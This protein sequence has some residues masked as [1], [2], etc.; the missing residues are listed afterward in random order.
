VRDVEGRVKRLLVAALLAGCAGAP[1]LPTEFEL[2]HQKE[3]AQDDD[4]A[5]L[6]YRMVRTDCERPGATPRPKNDCA[7][8]VVREAQLHEKHHRWREA[9]DAWRAVEPRSSDK[10]VSARALVRAAVVAT[11]ELKQDAQAEELAWTTIAR[12][13]DEVP[14]D[15]A[16]Q[17]A[18]RLGK[19]RDAGKLARQLEALWPRVRQLDLGDNVLWERAELSRLDSS[20]PLS[21]IPIYDR[22]IAEYPRSGLR[23]DALWRSAHL[24]REAGKP[25]DALR[26]LQV[27]LDSRR[28]ALITGSYNSIWLDDAQLLKGQILLD[29]LHDAARAAESFRILADDFPESVLKDDGLYE[30]ARALKDKEPAA[31]CAALARLLKTHPDSNR[32]RQA[33]TLAAE[34]TC[35]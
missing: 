9:F 5:L 21:A 14:A 28:D 31:A 15:D 6:L 2:A 11:D 27:I 33:K 19:R 26:R 12:Y 10:R 20:E 4:G 18:V 13:P 23:D 25:Q 7:I 24:L 35:K 3:A 32:T 8:A 17:L 34:L 22:L 29:D 16:L 1:P 30:L